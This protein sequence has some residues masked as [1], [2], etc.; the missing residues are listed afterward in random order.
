MALPSPLGT[1]KKSLPSDPS[2]AKACVGC[3]CL[4]TT[5]LKPIHHLGAGAPAER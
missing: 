4:E 2:T 5:K 3:S 1:L